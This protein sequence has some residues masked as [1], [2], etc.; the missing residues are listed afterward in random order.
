[1]MRGS[2]AS[3]WAA[4]HGGRARSRGGA[5]CLDLQGCMQMLPGALEVGEAASL[6]PVILQQHACLP[7]SHRPCS[8]RP[9]AGP[10]AAQGSQG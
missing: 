8:I 6:S 5:C 9:C 10:G 4:F 7:T 3:R 1:M 2:S